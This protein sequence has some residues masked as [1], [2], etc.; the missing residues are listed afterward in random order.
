MPRILGSVFVTS[1]RIFENSPYQCSGSIAECTGTGVIDRFLADIVS[2]KGALK[3]DL[4]YKNLQKVL[5]M[6]IMLATRRTKAFPKIVA[7]IES[8]LRSPFGIRH[9]AD[10]VTYLES[11]LSDLSK[12][13]ERNKYLIAWISY[14]LVSNGLKS[15]I[16]FKPSYSDTVTRS[17]FNNRA[18]L[19]R[20]CKDFELL[21]DLEQ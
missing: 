8:V 15:T 14:F 6:L 13:E 1:G 17:V 18:L 2:K 4:E 12:D 7:I 16:T 21:L 9:K 20:K 19:F 5:S 11:Y 10:I 3:V